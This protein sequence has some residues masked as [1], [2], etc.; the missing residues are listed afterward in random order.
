MCYFASKGHSWIVRN[1]QSKTSV[2]VSI[3]AVVKYGLAWMP[4]V[5]CVMVRDMTWQSRAMEGQPHV[6]EWL[7]SVHPLLSA[8]LGVR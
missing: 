2:C 6:P 7:L 4:I 3:H 8:C 1:A 5:G